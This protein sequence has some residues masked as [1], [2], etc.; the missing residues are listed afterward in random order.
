MVRSCASEGLD[1]AGEGPSLARAWAS[2][3]RG[4]LASEGVGLASEGPS[5][6]RAGRR[7]WRSGG[8]AA[9]EDPEGRIEAPAASRLSQH[10][11]TES[12]NIWHVPAACV[13]ALGQL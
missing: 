5:P 9:G 8:L 7:R 1:H 11:S 10:T 4:G 12:I 6:A 2:P 3:A 13:R